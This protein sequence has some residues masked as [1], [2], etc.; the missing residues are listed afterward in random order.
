MATPAQTQVTLDAS[1]FISAVDHIGNAIDAMNKNLASAGT[2]FNN[3]AAS[4][5][6]IEKSLQSLNSAMIDNTRATVETTNAIKAL[7]AMQSQQ[8]AILNQIASATSR[9]AAATEALGAAGSKAGAAGARGGQQM[10]FAW[11]GVL[12]LLAVTT[13]RRLFLDIAHGIQGSVQASADYTEQ[14]GRIVAIHQNLGESAD[15]LSNRFVNLSL[16]YGRTLKEVA[17]VGRIA[18]DN[19]GAQTA[20]QVDQ[21][22]AASLRLAEVLG[23]SGPAAATAITS[24]TR[25]FRLTA[26]EAQ[27]VS[28]QFV[29]LAQAGIGVEA[30]GPSI[31]RVSAQA[32]RLGVSFSELGL[33]ME[34][35]KK[36]G[37][38]DAEV[39]TQVGAVLNSLERPT[40]RM[41]ELMGQHGFL[42]PQQLIQAQRLHGA[43]QL[44]NQDLSDGNIQARQAT[45][46]RRA[47]GGLSVAE[48]F[49]ERAQ[50]NPLNNV[51]AL[52]EG[53]D[54]ALR[55]VDATG[56]WNDQLEKIRTTFQGEIGP[57]IIKTI[58]D[59]F[60]PMGGLARVVTDAGF[61]IARLVDPVTRVVATFT[62]WGDAIERLGE[63][64]GLANEAIRLNRDSLREFEI[65]AR[66]AME[67]N[68]T[69]AASQRQI[70]RQ[71]LQ[72]GTQA[73]A[74]SF[75]PVNTALN[76]QAELQ[77]ERVH[78]LGEQIEASSKSIFGAFGAQIES[79]ET[80]ARQAESRISES[81]KRVGE[82]AD[83]TDKDA[84]EHR[85]RSAGEVSQ[86][87]PFTSNAQ[88]RNAFN[89]LQAQNNATQNQTNLI[90]DRRRRLESEIAELQARG[91]ADSIASARRRFEQLRHLNDQE[92]DL[93]QSSAR[94][95]AEYEARRTGSNQEFNPFNR[96]REAGA[97]NL[98]AAEQAFEAAN[99]SRLA[100]QQRQLE[101]I[102]RQ[103]RERLRL[104]QEGQRAV[105]RLP[106]Q[107]LT[108]DGRPRSNFEG[109]AGGQRGNDQ[110][111]RTIDTQISRIQS[112][113]GQIEAGIVEALRRGAITPEQADQARR[114]APSATEIESLTLQL[115][116]QRIATQGLFQ[117]GE[118][119][120][121]SEAN[122]A[123]QIANL[124]QI[125]RNTD[126]SVEQ[127]SAARQAQI[128]LLRQAQTQLNSARERVPAEQGTFANLDGG[129]NQRVLSNAIR[130]QLLRAIATASN[131]VREATISGRPEDI[132]TAQE[133]LSRV[134]R[135]TTE[136]VRS[137]GELPQG[138]DVAESVALRVTMER[139]TE[140]ITNRNT[141]EAAVARN[142]EHQVAVNLSSGAGAGAGVATAVNGATG[143]ITTG[144]NAVAEA[145]TSTPAAISALTDAI[146]RGAE[147]I[148]TIVP[149]APIPAPAIPPPVIVNG[150]GFASGGLI[151]NAFSSFGPDNTMI[152]ARRGEFVVNPDST[153]KF[154]ATL[155][156]INRGD[157]PRGGGYSH[158]GTVTTSIGNMNFHV[159]GAEQPEQTARAVMKI[160]RREQRRGNV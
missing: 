23:S 85:L 147:A 126:R 42:S 27:H 97:R 132:T 76:R 68:N 159:S 30:I 21:I 136:L 37:V 28:N 98:N 123:Q 148:R 106:Q 103:L 44:I 118:A 47:G 55:V 134:E 124:Q 86:V 14:V 110:I 119:R 80:A 127:A 95:N 109:V 151:G 13:I 3:F 91:D 92:F 8:I 57:A 133:A 22:T 100:A 35:I 160:I 11:D 155:V 129:Q 15:Q 107:L 111:N 105:G 34:E 29:H 142:Q 137:R 36:T 69:W 79:L 33:L 66:L 99:R 7:T 88:S 43:L 143:A 113:P 63:R 140:A 78:E 64:L 54:A 45:Q 38:S 40:A 145:V 125:A 62:L 144:I 41:N 139:L 73:I 20:Q 150:G 93:R 59:I 130:T 131:R 65:A 60:E 120:R 16:A 94:R 5:A 114:R 112:L 104:V 156:A 49:A 56:K 46:S 39:M 90:R 9:A 18:A 2:S 51:N 158:G 116:S 102:N 17:Q 25:A 19:G 58:L 72:D 87:T 12:R 6:N 115:E 67:V 138:R 128:D 24:V 31:G 122:Q 89:L 83:K 52:Q 152:N 71:A 117:N 48:G 141:A 146:R 53:A 10:A 82:F 74:N 70:S 108:P 61:Q 121:V 81:L 4:S 135:L 84:F 1:Q 32:Q 96:E 101:E 154:Y 157:R 50:N 26:E 77:R 153:R 75:R 149:N